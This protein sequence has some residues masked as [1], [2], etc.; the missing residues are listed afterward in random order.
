NKAPKLGL[1]DVPNHRSSHKNPI[2]RGAGII[3][4]GL[5]LLAI[6]MKGFSCIN[7]NYLIILA[8]VLVY[9]IGII[10]DLK[11]IQA[12]TK[13]AVILAAAFFVYLSGY[14][15]D[16]IG[17]YFGYELNLGWAALP[18][19]L[20]AIAA[21]TNAV[22]LTDG[23]DGLAGTLSVIMLSTI[24]YIGIVHDDKMLMYWSSF[25][26]A[27][28]L[29]F[30]LLNWHPAKVFMGDT[31]SLFLGF[32]IAVLTLDAFEYLNPT[33]ILF[34]AA[35]PILDTLIVFRRRLQR[36]KSP[37]TPDKNH[38][39][40]ILF[41]AKQDKAFTVRMLIFM[42]L[43]FSLMFIQVHQQDDLLNLIMFGILFMVF[44][45][46]FDPRIRRRPKNAIIRKKHKKNKEV[47]Q[48]NA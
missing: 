28:L 26:I 19:T 36:G 42:Q 32:V 2:P 17:T 40:H 39:H 44:F 5:F 8:I 13:L 21:F 12:K 9:I 48:D 6:T 22:N 15:I 33:S 25:L 4:G 38:M 41:N 47:E 7:E 29:G 18:F 34:F 24:L 35:M 27:V 30:L 31:G 10:D 37:F 16:S 1:V 11:T 45:N 46:L 3:F 14:E 43:S 23:L 20:F